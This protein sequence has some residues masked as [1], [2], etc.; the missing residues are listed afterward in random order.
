[1]FNVFLK[2]QLRHLTA[3]SGLAGL[4]NRNLF[5]NFFFSFAKLEPLI[6][7]IHHWEKKS[8]CVL[9][10]YHHTCYRQKLMIYYTHIFRLTQQ[11]PSTCELFYSVI[12]LFRFRR[13]ISS[14]WEVQTYLNNFR[15]KNQ[16]NP[17]A[18][19]SNRMEDYRKNNYGLEC[20]C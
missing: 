8:N 2:L 20:K 15:D 9:I 12:Q 3:D 7:Q 4:I 14:D 1:M 10:K 5:S 6:I 19:S 11:K 16:T 17:D 18:H 13:N